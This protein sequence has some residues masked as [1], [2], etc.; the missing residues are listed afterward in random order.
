[1]L[2][3]VVGINMDQFQFECKHWKWRRRIKRRRQNKYIKM[4]IRNL[5]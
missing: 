4:M 1:M 2:C 3:T 5:I